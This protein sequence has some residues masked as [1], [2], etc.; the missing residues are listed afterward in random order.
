M[1]RVLVI[2]YW[3]VV[4]GDWAPRLRPRQEYGVETHPR[5]V[6]IRVLVIGGWGVGIGKWGVGR[7]LLASEAANC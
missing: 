7:G 3:R 1:I 2:G 5:G 6:V 4:I